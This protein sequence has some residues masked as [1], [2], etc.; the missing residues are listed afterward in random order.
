MAKSSANKPT[1]LP[2]RRG[3]AASKDGLVLMK[4]FKLEAATGRL[5]VSKARFEAIMRAA[6]Q[7]GLL[8][9]KSSRIG[10]RVSPAL[11]RQ[12]KRQTGIE[13]DTDLIEFALAT[14]ALEDNFAG[15]FKESRCTVDPT[16]KLGF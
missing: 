10:G 15:A 7:S 13:T 16:L 4:T 8:S 1:P 5:V 11:V 2:A 14:V 6:E 3:R 12:A 9:E